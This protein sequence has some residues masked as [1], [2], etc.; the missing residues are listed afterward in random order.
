MKKLIVSVSV[1]FLFS[2][3][4]SAQSFRLNGYAVYVFDDQVEAYSGVAYFE[5]K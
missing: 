1:F 4:A 3:V 5:G 2:M